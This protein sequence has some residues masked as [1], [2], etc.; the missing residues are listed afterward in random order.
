[1]VLVLLAG[2]PWAFAEAEKVSAVAGTAGGQT[3]GGT[4]VH[5]GVAGQA[6]GGTSTGGDQ[7]H[8]AG[9][10]NTFSLLPDTDTDG[11]GL[12]NE[13]DPD[14]DG[15][16]LAD[17]EEI[18]G[19]A[20]SYLAATNPNHPDTD[21]DGSPDGDEA[22][23]GTNPLNPAQLLKLTALQ[24]RPSPGR[25]TVAWQARGDKRYGV[26]R[27]E[28]ASQPLPGTFLG[29]VDASGGSAPWFETTAE[30]EDTTVGS[31][32]AQTYYLRLAP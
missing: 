15:D 11:N 5:L 32:A 30:F 31:A 6:G 1:M 17:E 8:Y 19:S 14:N 12:E 2:G 7:V 4:L 21:T 10:L 20:F 29:T 25:W 24:P 18:T 3:A 27:L 16:R 13:V 26:Y 9:F 23:A 22:E 28:D